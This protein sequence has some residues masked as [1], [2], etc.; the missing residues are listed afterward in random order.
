[1]REREGNN[2]PQTISTVAISQKKESCGEMS[3]A[4][5]VSG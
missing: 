1:M 2:K 5:G 4:V 3:T